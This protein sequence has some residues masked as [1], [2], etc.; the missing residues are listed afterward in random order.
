MKL[1]PMPLDRWLALVEARRRAASG[2][3]PRVKRTP[4]RNPEKAELLA[5]MAVVRVR[6]EFPRTFEHL[7]SRRFRL[8]L[9]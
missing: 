9:R 3:Y 8:R 1:P 7:G 5:R 4:P 2:A 6:R